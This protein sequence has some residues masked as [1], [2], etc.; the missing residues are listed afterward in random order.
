ME[1]KPF[2]L[3]CDDNKSI[4]QLVVFVL[5]K[6]GYRAQAVSSALDC[7]AV[8]R[9]SRPD[10]IIM[11]ILMPGMDGATASGLMKDILELQGVPIVFLSAMPQE[12]VKDRVEEAGVTGYL[13]KPFHIND[14]MALV[15]HCLSLQFPLKQAV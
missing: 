5:Q 14:L 11:D 9:R 2:I 7:V 13:L 12:Q 15:E 1:T 8:A 10:A 6:A 4:S 3:V